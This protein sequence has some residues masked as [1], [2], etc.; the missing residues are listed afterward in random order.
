VLTTSL[1][2]TVTASVGAQAPAAGGTGTST[3]TPVATGQSSGS[4][5]VTVS[6]APSLVITPPTPP[7]SRGLPASFTFAVTVAATNGTA[8]RDVTVDWDDR[9]E[10]QH[11]GAISGNA[12]V[13]HVFNEA[14]TYRVT[15]TVTDAAGNSSSVSTS[16]TV[17]PVPRPT[18]LVSSSPSNP[19]VGDDVT[20]TI[21]ITLPAGIGANS[22][23]IDYGDM[24]VDQLGGATSAN[25]KHKYRAADTYTVTVYVI[26]T[27]MTETF[28]TTRVTVAPVAA[29]SAR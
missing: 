25:P 1:P 13:S 23:R 8:V 10:L 22:T 16:V 24:Q 15:G 7:P 26:D 19:R 14:R 20:F 21:Q 2:A 6:A 5:N 29:A 4:V 3:T 28:G 27:T 17:I 12:V 9:S 18:I 11:L